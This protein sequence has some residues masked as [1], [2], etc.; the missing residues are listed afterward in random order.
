MPS[1]ALIVPSSALI[2]HLPANRFPNK[3]APNVTN[4]ILRNPLFCSFASFSIVSLTSFINKPD[5]SSDL[6]I[7]VTSFISSFGIINVVIPDPN[8][9]LL[10]AT[11]VADAAAVK[12]NVIKTF[13]ANGLSTFFIKGNPVFSNDPKS[14]LKN[15]PDRPILGN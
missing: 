14:P 12:P 8:I 4:N 13:L 6:T 2:V 7:I 1:P 9:F 10:I 15:L 11:S 5:Y 3:L